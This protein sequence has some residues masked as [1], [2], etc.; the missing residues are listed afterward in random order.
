MRQGIHG[1]I[2][3]HTSTKETACRSWQAASFILRPASNLGIGNLKWRCSAAGGTILNFQAPPGTKI[4]NS[5]FPAEKERVYIEK[6]SLH[7]VR[8]GH[9][10]ALYQ[11]DRGSPHP[12][13]A[14][15]L[16]NE[17]RHRRHHRLRHHRRGQHHEL[18]GADADHRV[19]CGPRGR[20]AA[21]DRRHRLQLHRERPGPVPGRG[22]GRGRRIAAGDALLQQ[23]QPSR[24]HPPLPGD[25]RRRG[26]AADP[27]RRTLPHRR[28]HR[29]GD[30]CGACQTP[31]HQRRQG[32]GGQFLQ[33]SEDPE[34]VPGGL[35]HLVRQR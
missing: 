17:K 14:A 20:A 21:G 26:C 24:A 22:A 32:G 1:L 13:E 3:S 11:R 6:A 25:R 33:H 30:V 15:G 9:C 18:P 8:C 28:H 29:A 31:Q 34:P 4:S 19:L 10:H 27:V 12:G 5:P 2:P 16:S 7:R 23:G 35:L